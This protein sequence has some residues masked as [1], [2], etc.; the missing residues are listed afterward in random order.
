MARGFI[1]LKHISSVYAV[2]K[3]KFD[4]NS[5]KKKYFFLILEY[6]F[7]VKL[8]TEKMK[9]ITPARKWH[10]KASSIEDRDMWI[11]AIDANKQW[12]V[13]KPKHPTKEKKR[14]EIKSPKFRIHF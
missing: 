10:F 13:T 9:I 11:Q 12:E 1:D 8:H 6:F 4:V 3:L 5:M 7:I 14:I 2:D